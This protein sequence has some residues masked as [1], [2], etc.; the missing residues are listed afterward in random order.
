MILLIIRPLGPLKNVA[1]QFMMMSTN[2]VTSDQRQKFDPSLMV[3]GLERFV[4]SQL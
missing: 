2:Y 4:D 1:N 3:W